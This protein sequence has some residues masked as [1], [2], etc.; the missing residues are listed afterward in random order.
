[1]LKPSIDELNTKNFEVAYTENKKGRAVDSIEFTIKYHES[2]EPQTSATVVAAETSKQLPAAP[3][4]PL[5]DLHTRVAGRFRKLKLSEAQI[6]RVLTLSEAELTKLMRETYALLKD[7]ETG[8][9]AFDNIAAT[10][11]AR[12][13]SL[14]PKLYHKLA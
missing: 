7:F 6:E 8:A 13:T 1:M 10:T 9:K 2:T 14:Y 11:M 3:K 4:P 5:G 12:I